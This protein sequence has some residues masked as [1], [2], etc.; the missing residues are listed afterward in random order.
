MVTECRLPELGENIEKGTVTKVLI[1]EGDIIG[2]DQPIL[3]LETDKAVLEVPSPAAG[4][5]ISVH[6]QEGQKVSVGELVAVVS[7]ESASAPP[8][9]ETAP[10]PKVETPKPP[11]PTPAPETPPA[12]EPAPISTPAQKELLETTPTISRQEPTA[13]VAKRAAGPVPAAPSVRRL[14]RE[15]GV[16]IHQVP[17]SGP[18]G[19]ITEEDVKRYARQLNVDTAPIVAPTAPGTRVAMPSLP[20]FSRWGEVERQEMSGIRKRTAEAM[21]TAWSTIPHVTQ[22]DKADITELEKFRKTYGKTVEQAGGKLTLTAI[23]IK[24]LPA[25]LKKF[26]KFNCSIDMENEEIILKKYYHIGVAVDTDRGLLVPVIKDCDKKSLLQIS[27]ELSQLAERA[28]QRKTTLEEMQG[29]TFTVTNL[30][31]IGGTSF[32]PIVRT[33]EVAILGVSRAAMEMVYHNGEFVPRLMAPLSLSYDHRVI[34]GAD[35]ARFLRWICEALEQP[36]VALLEM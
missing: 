1:R 12:T 2:K 11:T 13:P 27:V 18:G 22:M 7:D 33:P 28:R 21:A 4:K 17:G 36:Y 5:V 23:L 19:R 8:V 10:P 15:I 3:E 26:P 6:V 24:L 31:G 30:G 9:K 35:G 16:D 20:D 25:A 14:A 34:D 29:G 32:T